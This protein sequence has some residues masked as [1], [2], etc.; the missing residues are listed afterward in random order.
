MIDIVKETPKELE[1]LKNKPKNLFYKGNLSLLNFTKVSI[2]GTRHPIS[3]TKQLCLKLGVALKKRGIVVVSGGAMGVDALA[4]KAAFPNTIGVMANSLDIIYPKVN[5]SLLKSMEKESLLLSEYG[6]NTSATKYS[7]VLRNRIVVALGEVLVVAQADLNSGSMRSVEIAQKYG[8]KIYVLPHR[9]EDSLGT[10]A[11]L[12]DGLATAIYDIE[13]FAN[14]FGKIEKQKDKILDFC[15]QNSSLQDAIEKF[16]D[17]I[18]EYELSGKIE[19]KN[20]KVIVL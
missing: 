1:S 14:M 4:H 18:Y 11:L 13:K 2:V 8:K 7:F 5:F 10:N 16:G 3:Y 17:K 19:I 6:A 12:R 15:E 9:L 20:L